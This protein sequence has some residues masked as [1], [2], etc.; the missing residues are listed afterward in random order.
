MRMT[1]EFRLAVPHLQPYTHILTHTH[2]IMPPHTPH[3]TSSLQGLLISKDRLGTLR[4][5]VQLFRLQ[6]FSIH[7]SDCLV[8]L[9]WIMTHCMIMCNTYDKLMYCITNQL[10][11]FM[12]KCPTLG[13]LEIL[14]WLISVMDGDINCGCDSFLYFNIHVSHAWKLGCKQRLITLGIKWWKFKLLSSTIVW[15]RKS[16]KSFTFDKLEVSKCS[17]FLLNKWNDYHHHS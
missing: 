13:Y 11:L 5:T 15:Q 4:F 16:I 8:K 17:V 7:A 9:G 2:A 1:L 10:K 3:I 14:L 12:N 6:L